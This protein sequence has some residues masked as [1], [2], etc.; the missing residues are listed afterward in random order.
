[1]RDCSGPGRVFLVLAGRFG[2]ARATGLVAET[3]SMIDTAR[4]PFPADM[5]RAAARPRSGSFDDVAHD[6]LDQVNDYIRR[7]PLS[8]ALWALGIGFVL[9]WK[10]KPW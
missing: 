8:A 7:E 4:S 1:M 6:L 3:C 2:A 9:G 5:E 10:L